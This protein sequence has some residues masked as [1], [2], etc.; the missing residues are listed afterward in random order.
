MS[1]P[2]RPVV[3]YL[4][5]DDWYFLSHRLPMA[6][7][8]HPAGY[9]I[10]SRRV[11]GSLAATGLPIARLNAVA[12]LGFAFARR[13]QRNR[14]TETGAT[15]AARSRQGQATHAPVGSPPWMLYFFPHVSFE[16]LF[17][18]LDANQI[19]PMVIASH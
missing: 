18:G 11:V 1:Q 5:T 15:R 13:V 19:P 2:P 14:W 9:E 8:A 6:E 17:T 16:S 4:V 10:M 12:G 3:L 7:A